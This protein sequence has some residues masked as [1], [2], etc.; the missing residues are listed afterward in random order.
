VNVDGSTYYKTRCVEF[1]SRIEGALRAL[2]E[3]REVFYRLIGLD[4][5]PIIGTAVAGLTR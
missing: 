5:S 2:L 1:R 4:D 3:P